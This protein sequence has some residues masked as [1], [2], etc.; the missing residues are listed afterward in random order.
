MLRQL[1]RW[2]HQHIFKVGWLLTKNYNTTT[3][4]YYTFFLPG[5]IVYEVV[6]WLAAGVLNVRADRAIAFPEKQEIGELRLTF[7]K[8]SKKAPAWKVNLISAAPLIAGILLIWLIATNIL[9]VDDA[10]RPPAG[11]TNFDLAVTLRQLLGTADF[12]LWTYFVFTI[13]N[14]MMPD[15]SVLKVW[16]WVLWPMAGGVVLLFALG[17]GEEIVGEALSGPIARALNVLSTAFILIVV[18]NITAVGLLGAIESLVE[19][20]T[21]DS[22][23]FKNGKMITM[24][25]AE[26]LKLRQ[27]E[28][29][30]AHQTAR[31]AG[32]SGGRQRQTAAP[33]LP[34]GAPSIYKFAFP[35]P[36]APGQEPITQ[37]AAVIVEPEKPPTLPGAERP[38]RIEP[39]VVTSEAEKAPEPVPTPA[40]TPPPPPPRPMPVFGGM[41]ALRQQQLEDEDDEDEADED[42]VTYETDDLVHAPDDEDLADTDEDAEE[43]IDD[44]FDETD[45]PIDEEE[46]DEE[47]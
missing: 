2:L 30:K 1:E 34:P 12:W 23:T 37:Q 38:K 31:P 7:V 11:S 9:N 27:E 6:Y 43:E 19:R 45:E 29:Q 44:E 26:A 5:I 14:T 13:G 25:R 24:T 15:A 36:A 40:P 39:D 20:I 3:V 17:V 41:A 10:L 8:L 46:E 28:R 32:A 18:L 16:R 21:G 47:A 33:A 4:F 22:A 35:I 42:D